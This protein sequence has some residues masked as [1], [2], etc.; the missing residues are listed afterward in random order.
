[1]KNIFMRDSETAFENA[2]LQGLE[3]PEEYMYMFSIKEVDA[4]KNKNTRK[5]E[6][7]R[8]AK[9]ELLWKRSIDEVLKNSLEK[10]VNE[11]K[12][13]YIGTSNL[14]YFVHKE[15]GE[16]IGVSFEE[17]IEDLFCKFKPQRLKLIVEKIKKEEKNV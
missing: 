1:M 14:D 5:Y 9:T 2:I 12:Y 3:S 10:G 4:F 7:Y 13:V 15:L 11:K 8:I 17:K 16:L 6:Y